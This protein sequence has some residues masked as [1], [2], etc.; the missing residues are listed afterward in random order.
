MADV[1]NCPDPN[2][3]E[4][5]L[6]G[7]V[8]DDS[9]VDLE[10][11]LLGCQRCCQAARALRPIVVGESAAD[12][13]RLAAELSDEPAVIQVAKRVATLRLPDRSAA[14]CETLA[15][16]N[17]N[18]MGECD[19]VQIL[20]PPESPAEVGRFGG[21]R[22]L[23]VLG[24]G[25]MGL[26]WEAEDPPLQVNT[27]I[28]PELSDLIM[29]LL[30]K[31]P[32]VR[33]A[34]AG[35]VVEAIREIE[36]KVAPTLRGGEIPVADGDRLAPT[37]RSAW[38]TVRRRR[39]P[40]MI[41]AAA[42]AGMLLAGIVVI[43]RDKEGNELMRGEVPEGGAVEV[44]SGD[45][46]G[47]AK[48]SDNPDPS[49]VN[50]VRSL[51]GIVGG[52]NPARP[53]S[54]VRPD[55]KL[56]AG[57]FDL[58]TAEL[59]KKQVRDADLARFDGLKYLTGLM[60]QGTAIG[61]RGIANL[62]ELP[63]LEG[64]YIADTNVSD[65]GLRDLARR[66]PKIQVLYAGGT[67]ITDAGVPALLAW[68]NLQYLRLGHTAITDKS[69]DTLA[70][71]KY[72]RA[73]WLER[74]SITPAGIDRLHAA[75][76][77]CAIV[78]DFGTIAEPPI[79][80]AASLRFNGINEHVDLPTLRYDARR[81]I[82]IEASVRRE[83]SF[84]EYAAVVSNLMTAE[85]PPG[86]EL[87]CYRETGWHFA[88]RTADAHVKAAAFPEP[89]PPP[90]HL[91]GVW[92]GRRLALYFD[93]KLVSFTGYERTT[94]ET[95]EGGHFVIGATQTVDGQF[96]FF[97]FL[98]VIDEVRISD[99]A[100]YDGDYQPV[101]RFEPDE[102][103]LALYHFDEGEGQ[104]LHDV[105][106]HGH[107]GKITGGLWIRAQPVASSNVAPTLRGGDAVA[108]GDRL[109]P[110][111]RSAAST[112]PPAAIPDPPPLEK[113]LAG[114]KVLTVSQDGRGQF[115]TIQAALDALQP[116]QAVEVLDRGPYRELLFLFDRKDV[117]LISRAGTVIA[118]GGTRSRQPI[119]EEDTGD[120]HNLIDIGAFRL[121]GISFV[122]Q[123]DDLRRMRPGAP[124]FVL[125][126]AGDVV[127]ENCRFAGGRTGHPEVN[128]YY[129]RALPGA[130][131]TV[132]ECLLDAAINITWAVGEMRPSAV[133]E[134]NWFRAVPQRLALRIQGPGQA[135]VVRHNVF[136]IH[137]RIAI[138]L[139]ETGG[140]SSTEIYNNTLLAPVE[141]TADPA[142]SHLLM[143][144]NVVIRNNLF[145][146][147]IGCRAGPE[148]S[149]AAAQ[150][151]QV[152]N[153]EYAKTLDRADQFPKT[154]ADFVGEPGFLSRESTDRDYLRIPAD[155]DEAHRGAGGEWPD[156]LGAL[157][158]GP[159]PAEGDWLTRWIDAK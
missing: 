63:Q 93:G 44:R 65:A 89:D 62:G 80:G 22:V 90:T 103:T 109:S 142:R 77:H 1:L 36:A 41:A 56:P 34:S 151:W 69:I 84:Q 6:D 86:A 15:A 148:A 17:E 125:G 51:G 70:K 23:R 60:L 82:T 50:W 33:P 52:G 83:P 40:W 78:S 88:V 97:H 152:G 37:S 14:N 102:H 47:P 18:T 4:R 5:L 153:N 112:L 126:A 108:K 100:R 115:Q 21:Y 138:D 113:W 122:A 149:L 68:K 49:V 101:S 53:Y 91:A 147:G 158:P 157:P 139:F 129:P 27:D 59:S 134:R 124:W 75:R 116:G 2:T 58:V 81:P 143:P 121:S 85:G 9:A 57:R 130:V 132:R 145:Q 127:I 48:P 110:P 30:A 123:A 35:A 31:D 26:V 55:E 8:P 67:K 146:E 136:D 43:I 150:G 54:I 13:A 42:A 118:T 105:S 96:R 61:D 10:Q 32:A 72:L 135:L 107:H 7:L 159:V 140:T 79:E 19:F 111:S 73:V 39:W 117:G 66:F 106:G 144:T 29:R 156:Y 154:E 95:K 104:V 99:V 133:I 25:G 141:F 45:T 3:L 71:L 11:H 46:K 74:T 114:R 24:A 12:S 119:W 38:S 94:S 76:P 92:D 137:D 155:S 20:D 120:F 64:V 87:D 131:L 28:A 16:G 98:G 128:L